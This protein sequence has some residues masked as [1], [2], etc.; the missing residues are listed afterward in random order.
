MNA[1][2]KTITV[3]SL[4]AVAAGCGHRQLKGNMTMLE[5]E[6]VLGKPDRVETTPGSVNGKFEEPTVLRWHYARFPITESGKDYGHPGHVNFVPKRFISRDQEGGDADKPARQYGEQTDA[7]RTF[8]YAGSFPTR[9]EYWDAL[10]PLDGL[11]LKE[12]AT[13]NANET[14]HTGR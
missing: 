11:P 10:G 14:R 8:S 12:L 3:L 1:I 9:K 6:R 5:V 7:Y 13:T 4:C 2:L